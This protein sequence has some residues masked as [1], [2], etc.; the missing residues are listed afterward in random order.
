MPIYAITFLMFL[1]GATVLFFLMY[2]VLPKRT[3]LDERLESFKEEVPSA[4]GYLLQR[5]SS[6]RYSSVPS[7]FWLPSFRRFTFFTGSLQGRA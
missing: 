3:V 5:P 2:M 1:G 4:E 7:C 6:A